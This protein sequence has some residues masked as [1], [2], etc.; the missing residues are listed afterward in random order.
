MNARETLAHEVARAIGLG[1][2][3]GLRLT[4]VVDVLALVQHATLS[5]LLRPKDRRDDHAALAALA[6]EELEHV[7]TP[8]E[9]EMKEWVKNAEQARKARPPQDGKI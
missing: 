4:E 9:E 3:S 2:R 6:A 1:L 8:S 7:P 5:R